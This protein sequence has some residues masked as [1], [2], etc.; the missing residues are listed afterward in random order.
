M[1]FVPFEPPSEPPRKRPGNVPRRPVVDSRSVFATAVGAGRF[2]DQAS[3]L[4]DTV[5]KEYLLAWAAL[6]DG[7]EPTLA[8]AGT[9][10]V[11]SLSGRT[12][13]LIVLPSHPLRVAWHVAYDNLV[14]YAAREQKL[15]PKRSATNSRPSTTGCSLHSCL[16]SGKGARSYS[17]IH[18]ASMRSAWWP[19]TTRNPR[20][21]SLCLLAP[22]ARPT[23]TT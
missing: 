1:E 20:P 23:R 15:S 6:L 7:P 18:S 19:T 22:L 21:P 13:G 2:Y 9:V 3:K 10:E 17:P 8:L 12:V 5:V 16:A 14:L 11:Q 4:F